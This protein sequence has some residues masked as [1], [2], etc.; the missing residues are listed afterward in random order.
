MAAR[1]PTT[2]K[3]KP[4]VDTESTG[5]GRI[6]SE[7]VGLLARSSEVALQAYVEFVKS[8]ADPKIAQASARLVEQVAE[9]WK[10]ALIDSA[11]LLRNAY[12]SLD[13]QI[14]QRR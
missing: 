4:P 5:I 8:L 3:T 12:S 7:N 1:K 13:A 6:V 14:K 10:T 11:R 2:R 9:G